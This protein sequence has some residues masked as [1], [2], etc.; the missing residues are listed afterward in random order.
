[1]STGI[2]HI[3]AVA[4]DPRRN[5]DFYTGALGLR[6][7]KKTVNFDDPSTYHLYYS[8]GSGSP[9]S[10]LT[11]FPHPDARPGH[12]GAGQA[13][14]IS[15][16]VPPAAFDFWL[17]RLEKQGI[18]HDGQDERFGEKF[19]SFDDPDELK[20]EIVAAYGVEHAGAPWATADISLA[21]AIRGFHS[22]TLWER[23]YKATAALLTAHFGFAADGAEENRF[24]FRAPGGGVGRIVDILN[25]GDLRS[26]AL[27]AGVNHHVAFRARDDAHEEQMREA[28]TAEGL[29]VTPIIDRNY[30][31]SVYFREPGGV[32]FEIATDPPG[33]TVDEPLETLGQALKLPAQYEAR[34][35][36]IEKSLP[37][38]S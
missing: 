7:V 31:H 33:F 6:L 15:F 4:S 19:V 14:G 38:L 32:L 27:G 12:H 10:V 23:D 30:F 20:L 35:A 18:A 1:M 21:E 5:V 37:S 26:G 9:G 22:V 8:D 13:V 24:R 3:T 25:T 34:R 17:E 2:H 29:N 16:A 28:L 11:F 36:E